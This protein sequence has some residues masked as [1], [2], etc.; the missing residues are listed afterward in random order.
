MAWPAASQR[1]RLANGEVVVVT[2]GGGGVGVVPADLPQSCQ[3]ELSRTLAS[4]PAEPD[5]AGYKVTLEN[6]MD[7]YFLA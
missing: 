4:V 6:C 1:L 3:V 5:G 2:D 7:H